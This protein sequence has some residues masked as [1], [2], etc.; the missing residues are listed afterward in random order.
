[1]LQGKDVSWLNCTPASVAMAVEKATLG[2]LRPSACEVRDYTGDT[3]GGTTLP[4][5]VA[6][7]TAHG[8]NVDTRVG[9]NVAPRAWL[10]TQVQAGRGVV[11]QGNT[12]PLRGTRFRSTGTGVNHAV[13]WN[14]CRGGTVGHPAECLIY[15]PAADGRTAGWGKA[16]QGPSWWP[17]DVVLAFCAA[18][19]PWGESDP[20]TLRSLGITGA[21]AAV[22]PD[23]EPHVHT[24]YGATRTSPF[25]DRVRIDVAYV[26]LHSTPAYGTAN[27]AGKVYRNDLF[28]SYQRVMKGSQLWLGDHNGNRWVRGDKVRNIGGSQ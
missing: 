6:Y 16:D 25:P 1:M 18:L 14:E 3:V 5:C 21:Y 12:G 10:A 4:Q 28:I 27:R 19:H 7:A 13:Y 23:T 17:Y 2:R 24:K 22:F 8:I 26:W 15:D 11:I 9:G 20:R